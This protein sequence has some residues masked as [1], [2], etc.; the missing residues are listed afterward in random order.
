MDETKPEA[1][2]QKQV[3]TVCPVNGTSCMPDWNTITC[4]GFTGH[5]GSQNPL[6]CYIIYSLCIALEW[7]SH[8]ELFV[9]QNLIGKLRFWFWNSSL[10]ECWLTDSVLANLD[11]TFPC[12]QL[13]GRE[14]SDVRMALQ[15]VKAAGVLC[16]KGKEKTSKDWDCSLE[17]RSCNGEKIG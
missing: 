12:F 5:L 15:S 1:V 16:L 11:V 7:Y 8:C 14:A 3:Q 2:L 13:Q 9:D 10:N 6:F 17:E 4:G